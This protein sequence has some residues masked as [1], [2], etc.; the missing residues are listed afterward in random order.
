MIMR[1]IKPIISPLRRFT[2]GGGELNT[3]GYCV[4][5]KAALP[6]LLLEVDV[7][8]GRPLDVG[9]D[10]EDGRGV[11]I[12]PAY[13]GLEAPVLLPVATG[14]VLGPP[15]DEDA[16]EVPDWA[17]KGSAVEGFTT[18]STGEDGVVPGDRLSELGVI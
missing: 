11:L 4:G 18:G 13:G 7:R 8:V 12:A 17:S 5:A 14:G 1:A 6:G 10:C 16:R 2:G 3:G 9:Y 15:L